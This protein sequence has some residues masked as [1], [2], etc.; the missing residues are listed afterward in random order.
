MGPSTF[1]K[2]YEAPLRPR[3]RR[4]LGVGT[5][6]TPSAAKNAPG[7]LTRPNKH[8]ARSNKHLK[9]SRRGEQINVAGASVI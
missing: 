6:S 4:I 2:I 8:A 9:E 7:P 5:P 1:H 3:E